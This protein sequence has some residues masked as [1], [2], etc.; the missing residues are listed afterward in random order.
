MPL[1]GYRGTV[2]QSSHDLTYAE[3]ETL[4]DAATANSKVLSESPRRR[5]RSA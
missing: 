5:F 4:T 1:S 3:P 2:E